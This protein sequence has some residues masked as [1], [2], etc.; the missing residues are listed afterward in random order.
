MVTMLVHGRADLLGALLDH[1]RQES[2][3]TSEPYRIFFLGDIIDR[4]PQ[5]FEAME[6]VIQTLDELP[7]SKLLRGNHALARTRR[8]HSKDACGVGSTS[9]PYRNHAKCRTHDH[10]A[11][12]RIRPCGS[13]PGSESGTAVAGRP[14]DDSPLITGFAV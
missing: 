12:P 8:R 5:S 11:R 10:R 4:G 7:G 2:S 1:L 6:L 13:S 9:R 14:D 3:S